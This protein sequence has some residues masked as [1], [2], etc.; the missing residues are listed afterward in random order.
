[1]ARG[2]ES[3][4]V[5]EQMDMAEQQSRAAQQKP[6]DPAIVQLIRQRESLQSSRTR[7]ARERDNAQNARYKAQLTKALADLDGKLAAL[8]G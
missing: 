2:W 6:P 5:E 1:M 7:I 4:S 3:K 8:A